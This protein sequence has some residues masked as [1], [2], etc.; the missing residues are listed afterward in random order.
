V[1]FVA[2]SQVN[3]LQDNIASLTELHVYLRE[4]GYQLSGFPFILQCNKQDLPEA[5]P[6]PKLSEQLGLNG[7]PCFGSIA[8]KGDKVFDTMKVIITKVAQRM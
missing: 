4:Q 3:R 6:P 1:V 5:I 7:Q 2:D 8:V